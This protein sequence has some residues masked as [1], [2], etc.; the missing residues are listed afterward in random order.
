MKRKLGSSLILSFLWILLFLLGFGGSALAA[1]GDGSGGG[2]GNGNGTGQAATS[3][4]TTETTTPGSG[5]GTGGGSD[6]PLTLVSA[7]PAVDSTNV[8]VDSAITLEFSKNV[9]YATV[10]DGNLKA[11][12]LWKGDTQVPADITMADDQ[13][14]PD[15]RNFITITPTEALKEGTL[16]TVKVDD[17]L[18]AKSGNV[19]AEPLKLN[20]TTT[21]PATPNS[22]L[23]LWISL[24][25]L[26]VVI[27]IIAAVLMKR[28]KV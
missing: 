8:A 12:T 20:F 1:G 6:E 7:T 10:R 4:I 27:M 24:G 25:A 9:A 26:V 17:T 28:K 3:D 2:S 13:L 23:T 18:A 11:V 14:E 15:L 16:Y 22:N 5:G 21:A 19:L